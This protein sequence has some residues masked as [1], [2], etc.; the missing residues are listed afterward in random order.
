MTGGFVIPSDY[1]RKSDAP[2]DILAFGDMML[3]RNVRNKMT[4]FGYR[5]PFARIESFLKGHDIVVANAEGPFTDFPSLT[6]SLVNKTLTFT[7][8]KRALPVLKELGFTIFSQANNHTRDFGR[9]GYEQSVAAINTAGIAVFGDAFNNNPGP[10]I[11]NV[12]GQKV[13]FV[14][15]HQYYDQDTTSTLK[16]IEQADL[17]DAFVIVYPHWGE[18]YEQGMTDFQKRTARQFIDAGA[19]LIL[20]AHPHVIE[21]IEIYNGKAIFYSL[22]NFIFDQSFSIPTSQGLAVQIMLDS[23]EISYELFPF[24]IIKEQ[25]VLMSD[26]KKSAVFSK[27]AERSIVSHEVRSAIKE[28][29]FTLEQE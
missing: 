3:D 7:F 1:D 4:E 13:A 20:G 24:D 2:L 10:Y 25:A 26:E 12:R 17:Q 18:E 19:D 8:D 15:Y 22:G 27:L 28:G 16:A 23:D 11:A 14:G 29:K 21:P 5:Y 6:A 9:E